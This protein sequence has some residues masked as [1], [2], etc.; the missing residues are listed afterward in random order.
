M[1]SF[2]LIASAGIALVLFSV[3]LILSKVRKTV[4]DFLL[5][6][7][8]F[9][10]GLNQLFFLIS[11]LD[12]IELPV[13]INLAGIGMVLLHAPLLFLFVKYS[14]REHISVTEL[15]H[16]APFV[17]FIVVF[18]TYHTFSTGNIFF[19]D[20]FMLFAGHEPVLL[21]KYGLYFAF[22]AGTYTFAALNQ[23]RIKINLIDQFHSNQTR[24][25][26]KW[27]QKWIFAAVIFFMV[28]WLI[29]EWSLATDVIKTSNTFGIVSIFITLYIFFVSFLGIRYT[30]LF[31][32]T[33]PQP[34][35]SLDSGHPQAVDDIPELNEIAKELI[36]KMENEQ[37]YRDPDLTL[38]DLSTV[39][40]IPPGK[41][42]LVLNRVIGKNFYSFINGYRANAFINLLNNPEFKHLSTLGIAFE[43]GFRSKS[44]FYQFFKSYTGMSPAEYKKS[45]GK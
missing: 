8:L 21:G 4:S 3:T 26:Y 1:I 15:I 10:L 12:N 9:A 19:R 14:F 6:G 32:D 33:I 38:T 7:W 27:L 34:L 13:I 35:L 18:G 44:T 31:Q 20:G 2:S 29:I 40:N 36:T 11:G 25:V 22:T 42:S 24:Q 16:L 17:I 43:C 30:R 28:T 39:L 45:S 37:L 5:T 23:I 41:V